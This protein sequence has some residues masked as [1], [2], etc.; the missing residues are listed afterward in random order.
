M[1]PA[2]NE[3][4]S[5]ITNNNDIDKHIAAIG[6]SVG[7]PT[8][9]PVVATKLTIA[10]YKAIITDHTKV[11]KIVV[12]NRLNHCDKYPLQLGF[13]HNVYIKGPSTAISQI[14]AIRIQYCKINL[15]PMTT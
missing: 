7:K 8:S 11:V 6:P 2:K 3:G 10:E 12:V 4:V 9:I 5:T 15:M 1:K 13:I 14:S